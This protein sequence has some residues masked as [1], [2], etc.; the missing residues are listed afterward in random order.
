M[1]LPAYPTV[2][3]GLGTAELKPVILDLKK[4]LSL[5]LDPCISLVSFSYE[6]F[7]LAG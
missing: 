3:S 1:G 4:S 5:Y 2:R 6:G 7:A